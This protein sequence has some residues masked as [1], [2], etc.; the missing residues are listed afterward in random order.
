MIFIQKNDFYPTTFFINLSYNFMYND[1][2]MNGTINIPIKYIKLN[3]LT[4]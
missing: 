3:N 1:K 4:L 2:L